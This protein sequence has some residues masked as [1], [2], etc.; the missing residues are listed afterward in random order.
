MSM[1]PPVPGVDASRKVNGE[2]HSALPAVSMT[3]ESETFLSRSRS[4]STWTCSC[5][6]RWPQMD[7]LATPV[8]ARQAGRDRPAREH[9]ISIGDS[10]FEDSAD[11]HDAVRR[12]QRLE[13][14][15]RLRHVRQRV[16]LRHALGHHLAGP[17]EIGARLEDQMIR[18]QPGHRLRA[19]VV[20]ERDADEQVLLDRDRDQLLD[21]GRREAEGLGLDLDRRRRELGQDVHRHLA[22][23]RDADDERCLRRAQRRGAGT[24]GS[25]QRS[26]A[27]CL[28]TSQPSR[29]YVSKCA[30]RAPR[31]GRRLA[32][33]AFRSASHELVH[34]NR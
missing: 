15:G 25:T 2:Y 21:L 24:S 18:R 6:S 5:R 4:G 20:E 17:V 29:A 23:L 30:E 3:C 33:A 19:D 10:V 7:T 12:R 8:D 27:S 34:R 32:V 11:H 1:K 31:R 22:K 13:H 16:R 28:E 14:R 9:P 26:N